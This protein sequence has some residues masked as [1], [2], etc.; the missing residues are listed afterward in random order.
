MC[1]DRKSPGTSSLLFPGTY[2]LNIYIYIYIYIY[3]CIYIYIYIAVCIYMCVLMCVYLSLQLSLSPPI[4]LSFSVCGYSW[5]CVHVGQYFSLSAW[6]FLFLSLSVFVSLSLSLTYTHTLFHIYLYVCFA[7]GW[8]WFCTYV[9]MCEC[10]FSVYVVRSHNWTTCASSLLHTEHVFWIFLIVDVGRD[11]LF[12][13]LTE[14][15]ETV[16]CYFYF[17]FTHKKKYSDFSH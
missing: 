12:S 3:I 11:R 1:R 6:L 7:C 2:K 14:K 13:R 4:S 5:F 9:G 15:N 10:V 8:A 16:D 17:H